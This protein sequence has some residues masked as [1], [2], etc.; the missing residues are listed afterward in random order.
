MEDSGPQLAGVVPAQPQRG[1]VQRKKGA[2][3]SPSFSSLLSPTPSPQPLTLHL[4]EVSNLFSESHPRPRVGYKA[5]PNL[6]PSQREREKEP[7]LQRPFQVWRT[8]EIFSVTSWETSSDAS[9][10]LLSGCESLAP[11][12]LLVQSSVHQLQQKETTVPSTGSV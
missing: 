7:C 9:L 6:P 3:T 5:D 1:Q 10:T 11:G 2:P 4:W 12:V 8:K